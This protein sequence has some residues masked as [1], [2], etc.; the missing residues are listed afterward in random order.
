VLRYESAGKVGL[1]AIR[2]ILDEI[3]SIERSWWRGALGLDPSED[4]RPAILSGKTTLFHAHGIPDEDDVFMAFADAAF[5]LGKLADWAKRFKIKWRLRMNDEDWGAVDP[6]GLTKP[7]REQ[8]G[9]WSGRA[10]VFESGPATWA[11]PEDRR[12][13]LLARYAGRKEV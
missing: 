7:L 6:T 5:I 3:A 4:G 13:G 10:R 8:M 11:I 1:S 2:S 12:S 9:K